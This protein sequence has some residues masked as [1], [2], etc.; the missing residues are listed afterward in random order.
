MAIANL[1]VSGL[2]L[3]VLGM[4]IVFIFLIILI[5]TLRGMCALAA[6][7]DTPGE[8][9]PASA[10]VHVTDAGAADP[11]II[12]VIGAAVARYRTTHQD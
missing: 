3:M 12:A 7:L 10:P 9:A 11:T 6:W 8:T 5:F 2:E 1:M 4:G